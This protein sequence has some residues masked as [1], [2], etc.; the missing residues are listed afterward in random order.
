MVD[1]TPKKMRFMDAGLV[2]VPEYTE[3]SVIAFSRGGTGIRT[4]ENSSKE[5]E[6]LRERQKAARRQAEVMPRLT[7]YMR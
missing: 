6:D 7:D 3:A 4:V 5:A 2:I 1:D